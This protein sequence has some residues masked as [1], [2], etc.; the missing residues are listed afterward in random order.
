MPG[1]KRVAPTRYEL[2][3]SNFRPDRELQLLVLQL[4]K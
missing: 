3:R 4:N 2:V 1:L